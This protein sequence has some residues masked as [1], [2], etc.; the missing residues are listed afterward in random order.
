MKMIGAVRPGASLAAKV[1]KLI[2]SQEKKWFDLGST[3]SGFSNAVPSQ[4]VQLNL[5]PEGIDEQ[6]RIGRKIHLESSALTFAWEFPAPAAGEYVVSCRMILVYDNQT[7]GTLPVITDFLET[8]SP[9][10]YMNL[11][12]SKRFRVIYDNYNMCG[13]GDNFDGLSITGANGLQ[14]YDRVYRRLDDDCVYPGSATTNPNTGG[15]YL[16]VLTN[17][18]LTVAAGLQVRVQHRLRFT[19]A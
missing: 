8:D 3:L 17:G 15:Y 7:N 5:I 6:Q 2:R 1:N 9:L 18:N 11:N 12:N 10:S 14:M 13:K 19:D 16:L 4:V